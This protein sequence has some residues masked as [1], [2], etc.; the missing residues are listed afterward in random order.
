MPER[1]AALGREHRALG[2]EQLRRALL[3][4]AQVRDQIWWHR[5]PPVACLRLDRPVFACPEPLPPNMKFGS[6]EID[7]AP[8]EPEKLT[9][10][11]LTSL[12][13]AT[14]CTR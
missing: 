4:L 10:A 8:L 9:D 5:H 12:S 14:P 13:A 1:S 11:G 6:V 3:Q 7:I 2:V